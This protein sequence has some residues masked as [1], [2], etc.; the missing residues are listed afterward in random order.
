MILP[1]SMMDRIDPKHFFIFSLVIHVVVYWFVIFFMYLRESGLLNHYYVDF[2]TVYMKATETFLRDP[3]L[4]YTEVEFSNVLV[5]RNLP[6]C[7]LYFI[8]FFLLSSEGNL[9]LIVY[10]S[11]TLMWNILIC[12]MIQKIARLDRW[13]KLVKNSRF[14][15]AWW[16][17]GIYM[18]SPLHVGEYALGQTNTIAGFFIIIALYFYLDG[19]EHYAFSCLSISLYFKISGLFL[20]FLL[21][22]SKDVKQFFTNLFYTILVQGPNIMLFLTCSTMLSHFVTLNFQ[23]GDEYAMIAY[24]GWGTGSTGTLA[25]L[26]TQVFGISSIVTTI[27]M[28]AAL[29]PVILY[30]LRRR[31][32][33]MNVFEMWMLL[34]L[35]FVISIPAFYLV[36]VLLYLGTYSF[37]LVLDDG[38]LSKMSKIILGIPTFSIFFWYYFPFIPFLYMFPLFTI[39]KRAWGKRD[40]ARDDHTD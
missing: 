18:L 39:L 35:L 3:D 30:T 17:M 8:P 36:H 5:Y 10:S 1:K 21:F 22:F 4:L 20:L 13:K 33:N 6:A 40:K 16:I 7:L 29:I 23:A 26:L 24:R 37:W 9:N 15:D 19:K 25:V 2:Y 11:F 32:H 31:R 14:A 12:I 34:I 27:I 38:Q 28:L